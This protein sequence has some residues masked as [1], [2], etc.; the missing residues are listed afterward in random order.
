LDKPPLE[1]K[2]CFHTPKHIL[3]DSIC[4]GYLLTLA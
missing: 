1:F 2:G 4:K 3:F